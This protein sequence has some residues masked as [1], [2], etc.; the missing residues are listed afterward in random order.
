MSITVFNSIT[1]DGVMQAP[2]RPDEDTRGGFA[3]GGWAAGYQ[4][5]VSMQFA[6]EGMS[7]GGGL[8][9]GHRTYADLLDVWTHA[10]ENPFTEVLT[11][12]QKYV[13]SRS[14]DTV[15]AY[16]ESTLLAGE[17][18]DTVATL[19]ER[20][21]GDL[22]ILGSGEL[23]R[24]LHAAGLIDRYILLIHPIV[25]GSGTRLFDGGERADLV[26]E[27]SVPTSTGVIIAQYARG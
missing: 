13:V 18:S 15:L 5:E 20:H 22:V 3:H 23:V 8:L 26:L 21:P 6:G 27:R 12:S 1:L 17:A 24:S 14:H 9:F 19:R 2:G 4:D 16:P 11:R 10:D 25:L 7:S